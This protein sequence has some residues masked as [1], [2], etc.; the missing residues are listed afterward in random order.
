MR[1]F[2]RVGLQV[3]KKQERVRGRVGFRAGVETLEGRAVLSA[4]GANIFLSYGMV[5]VVGTNLGDTG[6]VS[7][8]GNLVHVKVSNAQGSD[9]VA[10]PAADVNSVYFKG[11]SGSNT[12]S[13]DTSL[14][15]YL[16]GGSGN[17]VLNAGAGTDYLIARG[18]GTEVLNAGSGS[19]V[20]QA[21]GTGTHYLNGGTGSTTMIVTAGTNYLQGGS[22]T[23]TIATYG[24]QN[25][26]NGGSGDTYVFSF[27]STDVITPASGRQ[28]VY[29]IG[30]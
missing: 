17:N 18:Q 25:T 13:N 16:Y 26:I 8:Q 3:E 22:G 7:L 9:D 12:F 29:R 21:T 4:S 5:G 10:F 2:E 11:G 27:V 14:T 24:G 1:L 30:Y 20:L 19:A 6:S 23:N 28:S 15:G